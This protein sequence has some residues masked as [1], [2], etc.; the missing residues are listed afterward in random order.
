MYEYSVSLSPVESICTWNAY[1][2]YCDS[3]VLFYDCVLKTDIAPFKK[4]DLIPSISYDYENLTISLFV[5]D[6]LYQ[7]PV[8]FFFQLESPTIKDLEPTFADHLRRSEQEFYEY[9]K[10]FHENG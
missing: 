8:T 2:Y 1:D 9:G 7:Y 5:G 3:E 4:G 10:F 6:K